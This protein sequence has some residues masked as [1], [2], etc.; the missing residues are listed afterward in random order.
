MGPNNCCVH[1]IGVYS[2][3][4][5]CGS[6]NK[7][8][9]NT[10]LINK[11]YTEQ[12]VQELLDIREKYRELLYHVASAFPDESRHETALRYIDEA[13]SSCHG[14]VSAKIED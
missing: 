12:E 2:H 6:L 14:P 11:T 8:Q 4:K 1:G 13:E 10:E 7:R 9:F 5:K 3:C